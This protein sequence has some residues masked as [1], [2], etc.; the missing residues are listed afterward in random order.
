MARRKERGAYRAIKVVLLDGPDFQSLSPEA[1]WAF[2]TLKMSIG[3]SGIEVNY[4][5]A[6][7]HE[8]AAK[9]GHPP[10]RVREALQEL[11]ESGWI[12]REGNVLWIVGQLD[13]DPHLQATNEN[14]RG[15]VQQHV[16]G[17]PRLP[18]VE[19]FVQAH[20]DWFPPNEYK[21]FGATVHAPEMVSPMPSPIPSR[22]PSTEYR[23]PSTEDRGEK[24]PREDV[25]DE[26]DE[27]MESDGSDLPHATHRM[28]AAELIQAWGNSLPERPTEAERRKQ[29]WVARKLTKEHTRDELV[30]AMVGMTALF[31]HCPPPNGRNEPWDLGDL[32]RKFSKAKAKA[33]DHPD[34]KA[35]RA[36]AEFM[37][38]AA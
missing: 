12:R 33:L 24:P 15:S 21:G 9:T 4:P 14:H 19:N 32:E 37:G 31:P 36:E 27:E 18:I 29:K 2:V 5:A 22:S 11:D 16:D 30:Q 26:G 1:R 28:S 8:L 23:V 25:L 20:P 10:G 38:G 35:M 13:H 6:L 17:L 3:P 34:L 7:E